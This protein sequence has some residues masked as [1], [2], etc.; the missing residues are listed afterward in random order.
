[1]PFLESSANG[2][3][4]MATVMATIHWEF[5][6]MP[7]LMMRAHHPGTDSAAST[8]MEM[9]TATR[10]PLGRLQMEQMSGLTMSASS[11]TVM[12]MAMVMIRVE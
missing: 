1:M 6:Q 2:P 9:D 5:Q 10:T 11:Q 4:Q 3:T 8:A 7:V 12:V